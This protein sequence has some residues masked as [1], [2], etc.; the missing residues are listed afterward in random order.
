MY[1]KNNLANYTYSEELY[2]KSVNEI[3]LFTKE[4]VFHFL[5]EGLFSDTATETIKNILNNPVCSM[6]SDPAVQCKEIHNGLEFGL[7]GA[8]TAEVKHRLELLPVLNRIN[9]LS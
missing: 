9:E 5:E 8:L 7:R 1:N 4:K 2:T 3:E 6:L